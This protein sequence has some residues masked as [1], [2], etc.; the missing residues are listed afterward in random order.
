MIRMD[1]IRYARR[2]RILGRNTAVRIL[3]DIDAKRIL[4]ADPFIGQTPC[5]H[6]T[7]PLFDNLTN[8]VQFRTLCPFIYRVNRLAFIVQRIIV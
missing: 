4:R 6:K 2:F 7:A 1:T 8:F 5:W 3:L